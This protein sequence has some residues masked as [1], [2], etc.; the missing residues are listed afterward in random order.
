[1]DG[2]SIFSR[3]ALIRLVLSNK[4]VKAYDRANWGDTII[5]E[6]RISRN[7]KSTDA[8]RIRSED[9]QSHILFWISMQFFDFFSWC[10]KDG[11][12]DQKGSGDS[13][14]SIWHSGDHLKE[15][16]VFSAT[17]RFTI[18]FF[19]DWQP[20]SLFESE[21]EQAVLPIRDTGRFIQSTSSS[22]LISFDLVKINFSFPE[23]DFSRLFA[24]SCLNKK[25]IFK[26]FISFQFSSIRF[27]FFSC[28]YFNILIIGI[29][30][31]QFFY[32][33][34]GYDE[35][36]KVYAAEMGDIESA[37][38]ELSRKK[39]ASA[40]SFSLRNEK[41]RSSL[42]KFSSHSGSQERG[43]W[44]GRVEMQRGW[45]PESRR[46]TGSIGRGDYSGYSL[47]A[48]NCADQ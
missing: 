32:D 43:R 22:T 8:Y 33:A 6:R 25:S 23:M 16:R 11:E 37:Q 28:C 29:V 7:S 26:N 21:N 15:V 18:F 10:R 40:A 36:A 31:L 12:E 30:L 5:V 48:R 35:A 14:L 2:F 19:A 47:E 45:I 24:T 41:W 13:S 17:Y 46:L 3:A 42:K 1:L 38:N 20:G 27:F 9:G 4:G 44:D 39:K 34:Y